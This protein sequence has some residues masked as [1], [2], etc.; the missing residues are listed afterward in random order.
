MN[1]PSIQPLILL[2]CLSLASLGTSASV[3][4]EG[5]GADAVALGPP[6]VG[7]TSSSGPA[8]EASPEVLQR[9][10]VVGASASDGFNLS[11]KL[12]RAIEGLLE[13]EHSPVLQL[14][15]FEFF[16]APRRHA[17]T[18]IQRALEARPTLVVG[19]DFLF[20]LG[21]GDLGGESRRLPLLNWGLDQLERIECPLV[22]STLPDMREASSFMLAD[23]QKPTLES[24][25]ALNE[26]IL[27]WAEQHSNVLLLSLD[28]LTREWRGRGSIRVGGIEW[29]GES[30]LTMLQW[31]KL[32]PTLAGL[33]GL[34][35]H[36]FEQLVAAEVVPGD[37]VEVD[38][39]ALYAELHAEQLAEL[40]ARKAKRLAEREAEREGKGSLR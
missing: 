37:A 5:R 34:A 4:G 39:A 33:S 10:V 17:G 16:L 22:L 2:S 6:L 18:Q 20:W 38:P 28:G 14:A 21:Y 31:D 27:E 26:R 23:A 36:V 40:A 32:H 25:E 7:L 8:L 12:A 1:F 3:P 9:I 30:K 24:L 29:P 13:V 19:L 35:C 11:A 15:D